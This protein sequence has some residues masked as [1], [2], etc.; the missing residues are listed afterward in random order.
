MKIGD[1]GIGGYS[2]WERSAINTVRFTREWAIASC[3]EGIFAVV[4]T[5]GHIKGPVRRCL[6]LAL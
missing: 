5:E 6:K 2:N 1:S 3:L 4:V